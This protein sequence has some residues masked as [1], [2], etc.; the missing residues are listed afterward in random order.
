MEPTDKP[1]VKSG[2]R[3]RTEIDFLPD[4]DAIERAP[5]P[6]YI[7]STLHLLVLALV[8]FIVWASFS[9]VEK[10]V[11]AHG[12]L[13]N[14][15]QNVVVQPLETSI[16]QSINVRP[17]QVVRKGEVLAMLDPTFAQADDAQ[18]RVKLAS[19]ETQAARLERELLGGG[20]APE[21]GKRDAD[22]ELQD[23]L[24]AER[25]ANY[26][27][28]K[29]KIDENIARLK[30]GIETN[31]RDE[32][33]LEERVKS[34]REIEAMQQSLIDSN[35][36]ARMQLLE[37]RD[38]R[39][40]V[41]RQALLA[42]NKDVEMS[43]EL[44]SA[45]AERAA[46]SKS[47]RQ[48]AMEDLLSATR[49]RDSLREQLAKADKRHQLVQLT[50]PIDAV[51]LD[52][53]KLSQGSVAQAAEQ[54]FTLVPLGAKLEAE[55]EIDSLD[56]GGIKPGD[57]A[58][59]KFDAFPFQ[60]HGS[61]DGKVRTVSSDAF[62]RENVNP[63]EGT[64]AYYLSRI[65]FGE[66]KLRN[67]PEKATLLPGMTVTAELVVGKRTVMSYLMWPLTRALNESLR[68]P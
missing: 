47:W 62:K 17:G 67:M 24:A 52:V 54:M 9:K 22:T 28:Q 46:F 32:K 55:V 50:A 19:L 10:V 5:L 36:G 33:V 58:H 16:V 61:I 23:R 15:Q 34:L 38:R 21:K 3:G 12:R 30:A 2:P 4:A 49:E 57:V 27:A 45:V 7:R 53:G 35:Y 40:E 39:L 14:P 37:A 26:E 59:L 43:R 8:L 31:R 18:L 48:K 20:A 1:P 41:E 65:Q 51:V 6:R 42:R 68:E 25:Q 56:V 13:V 44:A 66:L 64:N 11:I 60:R 63:G 29:S